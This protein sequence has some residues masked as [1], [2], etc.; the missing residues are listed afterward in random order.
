MKVIIEIER[1][2]ELEKI[3]KVLKGE[4]ITVVKTKRGREEIL[5]NIFKKY[6][7]KLPANYKFDREKIH[8]R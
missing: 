5:E 1:D 3:G 7:V 2:E 4:N 8:A 6:N